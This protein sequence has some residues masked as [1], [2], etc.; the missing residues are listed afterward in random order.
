MQVLQFLV[1]LIQIP[2][3]VLWTDRLDRPDRPKENRG[4]S[5][6]GHDLKT[7]LACSS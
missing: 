4:K 1:Q 3:I 2:A 7:I 6:L 5:A